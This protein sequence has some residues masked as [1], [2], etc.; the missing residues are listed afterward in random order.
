MFLSRFKLEKPWDILLFA[1]MVLTVF[2]AISQAYYVKV[3]EECEIE[4]KDSGAYI[5][6]SCMYKG[7]SGTSQVVNYTSSDK[8]YHYSIESGL[9]QPRFMSVWGMS[10][11]VMAVLYTAAAYY[12]KAHSWKMSAIYAGF[13]TFSGIIVI[14]VGNLSDGSVKVVEPVVILM[15]IVE[16]VMYPAALLML[17][18][19]DQLSIDVHHN[20]ER[21]EL[22][23]VLIMGETMLTLVQGASGKYEPS[24][25]DDSEYYTAVFLGFLIEF[26]LLEF[27]KHS[28]PHGHGGMDTH[29]YDLSQNWSIV[30]DL[31]HL[32]STLGLFGFGVGLKYTMKYGHYDNGSKL[33]QHYCFF[34]TGCCCLAIVGMN[35]GR[36]VHEWADFKI[37]GVSRRHWWWANYVI[38]ACI[39]PLAF[40]VSVDK[41]TDAVTGIRATRFLGAIAGILFLTQIIDLI[42]RPTKEVKEDYKK[43]VEETNLL[44]THGAVPD[45]VDDGVDAELLQKNAVNAMNSDKFRKKGAV[46]LR[47]SAKAMTAAREAFH[48][49][50]HGIET[51]AGAGNVPQR[52]LS[53]AKLKKVGLFSLYQDK[54]DDMEPDNEL[55]NK[56]MAKQAWKRAT[57]RASISAGLKDRKWSVGALVPGA[58]GGGGGPGKGLLDV[59]EIEEIDVESGASSPVLAMSTATP[60]PPAPPASAKAAGIFKQRS[61]KVAPAGVVAAAV[62][63][64]EPAGVVAA[65]DVAEPGEA[66]VENAEETSA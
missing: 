52:K 35:T 18:E 33:K 27:Y 5:Y 4:G 53:L 29:I 48:S 50:D 66:A 3:Y 55:S 65:V 23:A 38:A 17:K 34:I 2:I 1:M 41:E 9:R 61:S 49:K 57:M 19:K 42:T 28:L 14:L 46:K 6:K 21:A 60:A 30:Y 7:Y 26:L 31:I 16:F 39:V 62:D 13:L 59:Q 36:L 45:G 15:I 11:L 40:T 8:D 37:C 10:R 58:G 25:P 12:N 56:S 43:F 47:F 20:I 63:V 24:F 32:L 64:A 54:L 51:T 44:K 22:W